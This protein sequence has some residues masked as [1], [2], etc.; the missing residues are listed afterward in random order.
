MRVALRIALT[1]VELCCL[2][3]AP[4]L[5]QRPSG[6]SR[7]AAPVSAGVRAELATVLLQSGRYDEAAREFRQLIKRNPSSFEYRL[8]LARALAWGN[9]PAEAERELT[10]LIAKRPGTPGLD[11]LLRAVR[12]AYDP[13]AVDAA[14]WVT[15]DP[16][17]SPYRLALARALAREGMPRLAILHYDTL[18]TRP[19]IGRL[20]DRGAL[21]RELADAYV[22]AGDRVGGADHLR[23]ALALA[24][25]DIALRRTLA[26]MLVDARRYGEARAQYDT[27]L[28]QAPSAPLFLER[29]RLRLSLGDRAG[30]TSDLWMSVGMQPSASAY[31]LLGDLFREN[32]DYRGARSMYVA[33]RQGASSDARIAVASALAQLDREERPASIALLGRRASSPRRRPRAHRARRRGHARRPNRRARHRR[34]WRAVPHQRW[35]PSPNDRHVPPLLARRQCLRRVFREWRRLRAT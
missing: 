32:G 7:P 11:S 27:L 28:L 12:D 26:S 20:P 35:Q 34:P 23:A 16:W 25:A 21:L 8:G 4:V 3:A 19:A 33:A 9:H 22:A 5:A 13:R 30:A 29:A 17:Y 31:V 24:P 2:V 14:A 18:L 10:Q 15:S 6:G 1:S